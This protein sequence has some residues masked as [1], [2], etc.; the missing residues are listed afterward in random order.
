MTEF[1]ISTERIGLY[2]P[3]RFNRRFPKHEPAPQKAKSMTIAAGFRCHDG[4]VLCTD[5]EH[6]SGQSKSYDQ[7]IFQAKADNAVICLAGA[8][9]DVYIRTVARDIASQVNGQTLNFEQVELI[10]QKVISTI[11]REV[12]DPD[13]STTALLL[14]ARV[15]GEKESRLYRLKGTGGISQASPGVSVVGTEAAESAM[16]AL[17]EVFFP[18]WSVSVYATRY[19]AAHLVQ[20]V[21]R[22]ASYCGGSP[23]IACLADDGRTYFDFTASANPGHDY[24]AGIL[25]HLPEMLDAC[26][27]GNNER[28]EM[29]AE[30]SLNQFRELMKQRE[31]YLISMGA[32]DDE[33]WLW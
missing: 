29:F 19:L 2:S 21:N 4:V 3:P 12:N 14:A 24:L 7:K 30:T 5:S 32:G 18:D 8:G 33:G 15:E 1:S 27:S 28:F 17:A 10:A 11:T 13:A 20:R 16:R 9:D 23:Q 22:A 26:I 31:K 25:L 6:T